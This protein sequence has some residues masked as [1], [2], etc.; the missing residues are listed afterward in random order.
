MLLTDFLH[1]PDTNSVY[2]IATSDLTITA[3]IILQE[4]AIKVE[5]FIFDSSLCYIQAGKK[6]LKIPGAIIRNT[7]NLRKDAIIFRQQNVSMFRISY[8]LS[9]QI[10]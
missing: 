10:E 2:V 4:N 8:L 9:T 1:D 5:P 6:S 3:I 7:A